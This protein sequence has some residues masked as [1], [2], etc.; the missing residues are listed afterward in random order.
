MIAFDVPERSVC[1]MRRIRTNTPVQAL[2]TLNDPV[3]VEAAQ[4]LA[5]RILKEGGDS[6]ES[7]AAFAIQ[8]VLSRPAENAEVRRL[9]DLFD[10]SRTSLTSD[11]ARATSL[12]TKPLG[13][14]PEEMD[15]LDAAAW[16]VVANVL[17]N[18]DETLVKR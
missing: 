11:S 6:T 10:A 7:R 16:T 12:A 18:L 5:R 17:L 2:V 13:P 3:Y 15:A 14:L 1:S 4:A 8:T 9:V